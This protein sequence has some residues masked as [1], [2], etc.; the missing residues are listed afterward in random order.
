M[1]MRNYDYDNVTMRK[2]TKPIN[3]VKINFKN[4]LKF[5]IYGAHYILAV[6]PVTNVNSSG[7]ICH[8]NS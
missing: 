8:S 2:Q 3:K 4:T 6:F 1:I 5:N 7:R